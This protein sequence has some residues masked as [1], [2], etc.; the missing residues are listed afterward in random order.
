MPTINGTKKLGDPGYMG[1]VKW[2]VA[3]Y[4]FAI[5]GGAVSD[6]ALRGDKIPSG[7]VI[8]DALVKVSTALTSG[9]AATVAIKTEGAADINAADAISG[10]PWST[11]G[12]KRPDFVPTTAPITTTA[13]RSITAT[14]ATAALT[15][16]AFK[17]AIG[18]VEWA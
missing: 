6:I 8:V 14:V 16:G 4:D 3:E 12:T 1:E 5:D 15:A 13:E 18:Y 7:A 17:V 2:A 10:A 11:T 9:G